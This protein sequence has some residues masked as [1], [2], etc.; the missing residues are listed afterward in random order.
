MVRQSDMRRGNRG[1]SRQGIQVEGMNIQ[2]KT[3][4]NKTILIIFLLGLVIVLGV[5]VWGGQEPNQLRPLR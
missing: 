2:M 4:L 1:R 5:I 3:K